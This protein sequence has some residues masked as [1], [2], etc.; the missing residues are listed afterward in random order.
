MVRRSLHTPR[1]KR[2]ILE[3]LLA[4]VFLYTIHLPRTFRVGLSAKR[5]RHSVVIIVVIIIIIYSLFCKLHTSYRLIILHIDCILV[6]IVFFV[7][8][9]FSITRWWIKLLIS[10]NI[11]NGAKRLRITLHAACAGVY[12][13]IGLPLAGRTHVGVVHE[14]IMSYHGHRPK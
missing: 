7:C 9:C 6:Y 14:I 4:E 5:G 2:C 10:H 13:I 12:M 3:P 8:L 1:S 11:A